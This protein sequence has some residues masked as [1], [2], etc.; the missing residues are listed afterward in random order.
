MIF[1]KSINLTHSL[2]TSY[3]IQKILIPFFI[4]FILEIFPLKTTG[5][6]FTTLTGNFLFIILAFIVGLIELNKI[7]S[8]YE[9]K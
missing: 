6:F 5:S 3:Q 7:K 4:I 8:N 2:K 9:K 1:I